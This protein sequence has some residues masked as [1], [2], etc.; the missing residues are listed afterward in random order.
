[1]NYQKMIV[2]LQ[3]QMQANTSEME[4][5][6]ELAKTEGNRE[7]T[8]DEQTKFEGFAESSDDLEKRVGNLKTLQS[9][10]QRSV[11]VETVKDFSKNEV[12]DS[13]LQTSNSIDVS[14]ISIPA[15]TF[16]HAPEQLHIKGPDAEKKTYMWGVWT[17]A[18]MGHQASI[19]K[20]NE[21]GLK[22][23]SVHEGS[24]NTTG[25]YLVPAQLDADIIALINT[26]GL[27]RQL[28]RVTPMTSD[29][30]NRPRRTGGLTATWEGESDAIAES[31]KSWDNVSLIAK[32]LAVITRISNELNEDAIISVANDLVR[33]I[34][35]AFAQKEDEAYF[36][37][38][39][40]LTY[41][42]ITGMEGKF[43]AVRVALGAN[44]SGGGLQMGT[45]TT[46]A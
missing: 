37:G 31:T 14:S 16:R 26:Y 6:I 23:Q 19:V 27:A 1:M 35:I 22:L 39:G 29:V 30:L 5:L 18:A 25:G 32:K 21:W 17:A 33:E 7:L 11:V 38:N 41:G 36:T 13:S 42:G 10:Q 12:G 28:A 8:E 46:M 40:A 44:T 34:A 3:K 9:Q 20:C 24:V 2:E 45:G 43:D 4:V 15:T